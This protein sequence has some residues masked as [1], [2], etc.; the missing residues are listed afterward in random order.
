MNALVFGASAGVGRYL[1]RTLA[2]RGQNVTIVSRDI[3]DLEAEGAHCKAVYGVEVD[4]VAVDAADTHKV[5]DV[6]TAYVSSTDRRFHTL[7]FPVGGVLEDDHV[8]SSV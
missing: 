2:A 5:F 8:R 4:C 3:R 7:L 1:C 6:L